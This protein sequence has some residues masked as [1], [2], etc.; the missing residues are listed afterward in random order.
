[1]CQCQSVK[2]VRLHGGLKIHRL[3]LAKRQQR[4]S[5]IQ[6]DSDLHYHILHIYGPG[7]HITV[8]HLR[9]TRQQ[10]CICQSYKLSSDLFL[11]TQHIQQLSLA[12]ICNAY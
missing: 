11:I 12:Q 3:A 4:Q 2:A 8:G 6:N 9:P 1:M 10:D 7:V 5:H